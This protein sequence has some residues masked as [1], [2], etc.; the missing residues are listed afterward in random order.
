MQL[1]QTAITL[2]YKQYIKAAE[3]CFVFLQ[4]EGRIEAPKQTQ[5]LVYSI[6]YKLFWLSC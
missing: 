4:R 2:K 6:S 3:F 1:D 5:S